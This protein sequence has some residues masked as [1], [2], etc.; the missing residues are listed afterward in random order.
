MESSSF[1]GQNPPRCMWSGFFFATKSIQSSAG[2]EVLFCMCVSMC[3]RVFEVFC[4][5]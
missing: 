5:M 3:T 1:F 4:I 2:E